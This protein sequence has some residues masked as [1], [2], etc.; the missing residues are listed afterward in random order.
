MDEGILPSKDNP[1]LIGHADAEASFLDAVEKK[2]VAGSWLITGPKGIGKANLAYR[3]ARYLLANDLNHDGG[4]FGGEA[5]PTS[6]QMEIDHPIFHRMIQG[7]LGDMLVVQ[8]NHAEGKR[9]ISVD[10]VRKVSKFLSQTPSESSWRIVIVDSADE[11]NR[12]AANALLKVLEEPPHHTVMLLISHSP[13]RLLPTIRS[14]C[15]NVS[16]RPLKEKQVHDVLQSMNHG[17]L[18][19]FKRAEFASYLADGAPGFAA[20]LYSGS[21]FEYYQ[22]IVNIFGSLPKIDVG[23]VH[24]L[25][26][27][28]AGKEKHDDWRIATYLLSWLIAKVVRQAATGE[29]I[30]EFADGEKNVRD[31]LLARY[32]VDELTKLWEKVGQTVAQTDGLNMD[33]KLAVQQMFGAFAK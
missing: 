24:K 19:D 17:V 15:R 7:S 3:V 29:L 4:L 14:R 16:L 30:P 26:D 32:S 1:S 2:R 10:Q 9:E 6:L 20:E 5:M 25:G 23:A 13:G 27:K 18:D 22:Q 12:N 8:P 31:Q 28:L 33:K 11:M 21:G